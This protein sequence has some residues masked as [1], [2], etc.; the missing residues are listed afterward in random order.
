MSS[1]YSTPEGYFNATDMTPEYED[2]TKAL[3]PA[4]FLDNKR[5]Q[6][7]LD[8]LGSPAI[9]H[10]GRGACTFIPNELKSLF[11]AWMSLNTNYEEQ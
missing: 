10:R 7:K 6:L 4:H 9:V 8:Q 5:I 1:Q 2:G 11:V 3:K